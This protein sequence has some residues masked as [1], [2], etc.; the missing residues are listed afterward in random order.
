MTIRHSIDVMPPGTHLA[1]RHVI[2]HALNHPKSSHATPRQQG[3]SMFNNR[4]R[5]R[6]FR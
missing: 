4:D 3:D 1:A 5:H 6:W 2:R